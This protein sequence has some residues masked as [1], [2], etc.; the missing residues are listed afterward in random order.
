MLIYTALI[1]DE[2][3]KLR[4]EALYNKYYRLMFHIARG[5]L[6]NAEDAEDAVSEAFFSI[7]ENFSKISRE[8]TQKSRPI[9]LQWLRERR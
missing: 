4:F 2:K 8:S 3:E 1:E 6:N 9:S 5:I 7:A